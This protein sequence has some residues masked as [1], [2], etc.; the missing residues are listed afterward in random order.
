MIRLRVL[1][2]AAMLF[3]ASFAFGLSFTSNGTGGGNWSSAATW[4]GAGVPGTGDNVTITGSDTVTV[5]DARTCNSVQ[6]DTTGGVKKL[7]VSGT[8]ALVL[9]STGNALLINAPASGSNTVQLNG[10]AL[11]LT[12]GDILIAG[13]TSTVGRLDFNT[14]GGTFTAQQML[15]TGTPSNAQVTFSTGAGSVFLSGNLGNGGSIT[16]GG[17]TFTF[18][19]TGGQTI[20]GYTFNNLTIAK[21]SGTATLNG[22]VFVNG[23]LTISSGLLD[24]GGN[25]IT[26]NAG[27]MSNVNI[28]STGVLKLGAAALATSFPLNIN[29]SNVFF[30]PGSVVVYHAGLTQSINTSFSYRRLWL[31]TTGGNVTHSFTGTLNV[32]E[33]LTVNDNG[34][35]TTTLSVGT[36]SLDVNTDINGDGD[37]SVSS[38]FI[39]L[40]GSWSNSVGLTAGVTSTIVYDGSSAQNVRAATY[41]NLS[42]TKTGGTATLAGA[43]ITNGALGISGTGTLATNGNP[44]TVSGAFGNSATFDAGTSNVTFLGALTNTGTVLSPNATFILGGSSPQVWSS[45]PGAITVSGLQI[46][47][48]TGVT[49]GNNTSVTGSLTLNGGNVTINGSFFVDVPATVT[50][51]SG[52]FIGPLTMGFNPSP[53]RRMHLGTSAAYLPIDLDA[54]SAGTVTARAV[55]GQQPNKTGPRILNRYWTIDSGSV[56]PIDSLTFNYNLTDVASGLEMQFM[57][58]RYASGWI[59]HGDLV[60]EGVHTAT[61]NSIS[62]YVGD[63]DVGH[64]GSMGG[65]GFLKITQVNGGVSPTANVAFGIDV[66]ARTD[67]D[68]ANGNAFTNSTVDITLAAGSGSLLTSSGTLSAG[69]SFVN[70]TGLTYDTAESNVQLSAGTSS[71]DA[72]DSGTSAPFTVLSPPSTLTV[73]SINDSGP[74]TLRDAIDTANAFGCG[75][76]CTINFSTSGTIVLATPLSPISRS[77]VLIDGYTAPGASPNTNAFGLPDN[78]NITM[79]LDGSSTIATGFDVQGQND[80]LKGFVIKNFTT[81]GVKFTGTNTGSG[82][83]GCFVGTDASG[84]NAAPNGDGVGFTASS[85]GTAGGTSAAARN[86]ISGNGMYGVYAGAVSSNI[87]IYGN[88]IGVKANLSGALPNDDGIQVTFGSSANIGMLA[89]GNLI[90]GNTGNG[91]EINGSASVLANLIGTNGNGTAAIPN[92]TGIFISPGATGTAIG[93]SELN[94]ISGNTNQG[95][96]IQ[97]DNNS[98]S[99]AYIGV[100]SDGTTSIPNGGIGVR[101]SGSGTNNSIGVAAAN[102]IAHNAGEGVS[103]ATSALLVGNAIRTNKIFSNGALAIDL[104]QD[105]ITPND[106]ADADGGA[107]GLQNFPT[108]SNAQ[109]SGGN[110]PLSVSVDS[111]GTP[112]GTAALIIDVYKADASSPEQALEYLGNSGCLAGTVFSNYVFTVPQGTVVNGSKIVATATSYVAGCTAVTDGTSELSAAATVNGAIHWIN[113]SGGNWSTAGNWSPAQ[114]PTAS[115]EV[116]IDAGGSYTVIVSTAEAAG[117]LHVGTGISGTQTLAVTVTGSLSLGSA[118]DVTTTGAMSV[119]STLSGTGSLAVNGVFN[120]DGGTIAGSTG[121]TINSG[122]LLTVNNA[123]AH[124]LNQRTLTIASGA[125]A[126]WNAGSIS[127]ANSAHVDNFGLFEIK[128][129][130]TISDAGFDAGFDNLGTLRKSTTAGTTTFSNVDLDHSAGTIDIQTGTIDVGAGSATAP[131]TIFTGAVLLINSDTFTLG[132]GAT[133][134]GLGKIHITSGTLDVTGTTVPVEHLYLQGGTLGG[135]GTITGVFGNTWQWDGGTMSGSGSTI[136]PGGATLLAGSAGSKSLNQRTLQIQGSGTLTFGGSGALQLLNGGNVN[137]AGIFDIIGDAPINDA[138]FGGSIV[139]SGTFKKSGT[140]GGTTS[141]SNVTIANSGTINIQTGTLDPA[142]IN[143]TG[144]ITNAGTLLVNSNTVTLG[145]GS[146]SGAGLVQVT[147]GTLTVNTAVTFPN[148][149]FDG[150]TINGTAVFNATALTWNGG[151]M[152]GTGT[153]NIPASAS[154]TIT[155]AATKTLNQRSFNVAPTGIATFAG[156]GSIDMLNGGNITNNGLFEITGSGGFNDASFAGSIANTGTFRKSTSTNTTSLSN[157]NFNHSGGTLDIQTGT[158]DLAGGTSSAPITLS[159]GTT[160]LVNSNTYTFA[161]G[162]TVSGAGL[163]TVSGGTLSVTGNVAI[164][165]FNLSGGT[166]DGNGTTT[167]TNVADWSGGTMQGGGTTTVDPSATLT[168][169]TGSAKN[170][171]NRTLATVIGG[172]ITASGSGTINLLNGGNVSNAGLFHFTGDAAINDASFAGAFANTGTLRKS[173]STNTTSF[174]NVSLNHT[175]GTLDLQTGTLDL[176]GGTSSA[177]IA[178]ASGATLLFNSN[179]YTL[180][181]G[182]TFTGTGM[183]SLQGG[184]LSVTGNI[185]MPTF[186]MTAG[187]LDGAGTL[188]LTT[189]ADWSGGTMQGGGATT[190]TSGATLTISSP[191]A[192]A[193]NNRTLSTVAGGTIDITG[194][195]T[196]N[197]LNGGNINNAGTFVTD[198][199]STLADAGF[200]G[201]FTNTGTLRKQT[202]TGPTTLTNVA[203]TNNGGIVDLQTG[204]LSTTSFIQSAAGTLKV[205]LG[206]TAPTAFSKLTTTSTPTLAGTLEVTLAGVYQPVGGDVFQILTSPGGAHTGDFTHPYTY[207]ALSGGRTFSDAYNGSG[208]LLTVNGFAD[209]S[210]AKSAASNNFNVSAPISYTITVTNNSP[211]LANSVSVG[212]TLPAGHTGISASGTGWNCNVVG[213]TVTCNA[214]SSLAAGAAP[215]ITINATTPSTPQTFTNTATV[216]SANDGNGTN[217]SSGWPITINPNTVDIDVSS[218]SPASPVAQSTAFT[219]DFTIKNNGPQTATSVVFTAPIP[220]TL[221]FN[222]ATPDQGP[223][224]TFV[225][226]N[227]TCN[228]GTIASGGS[229]HVVL[230]LSTGTTPGT[231]YVT[232]SATQLEADSNLSNNSIPT[233]VQVIGASLTVTNTNDSGAGSL[234]QALL[235]A[236]NTSA[237]PAPCA[238]QFNIGSGPFVIQPQSDLPAVA[239]SA[240]V[241]AT[242]QPGYGGTP[243]IRLDGTLT[244]TTYLL[245]LSNGGSTVKGLSL[246]NATKGIWINSNNNVV[247]DNYIGLTPGSASAGNANGVVIDGSN[248]RIGGTTGGANTIAFN[249]NNGID[250]VTGV[251]NEFTGNSIYNNTL[252]G[253]D[254]ANDGVTP[255]DANDADTGANNLQN[256]PTLTAAFKDASN[257]LHIAYNHD[258]SGAANIAGVLVEIYKAD[259]VAGGQGK[260]FLARNCFALDAFGGGTSFNAPS[261]SVGDPIVLTATGYSDAGCTTVSDGTSEFSNLVTVA[262]CVPPAATINAPPN[263]CASSPSNAAS[264][265]AP[266]ATQFTWTVTGGTLLSGQG[267]ANITFSAPASGSV[268]LSV[269]VRDGNGCPNTPSTS[270]PVVAPPSATITAPPSACA[271]STGNTASAP[272]GASSYLWTITNGTITAGQNT[273]AITFTAGASGSVSLGVTA[274][275]GSCTN[276]G[277]ASVPIGVPP[278]VTIS[279]PA[280]ACPSSTGNNASVAAGASSYL[281]SITNGAITGGQSTNAIT[282]SA[283]ASGTVVLGV[284]V[285]N[286]SCTSNG[287]VS[288]PVTPIVV[289]IT[290]TTIACPSQSFVLDAGAGFA[291]YAWSTGANTRF[292]T[293][294]QSASSVTYNVTVTNGSCSGSD[295]HTVTLGGSPDANITTALNVDAN[296]TDNPAG[297]PAQAGASYSWTIT[298]GTITSG[299]GTNSIL[300]TAGASGVININVTVNAG[301]CSA[302]S[303]AGVVIN[304]VSPTCPSTPPSLLAPANNAIVTSPTAFS[305]SAVSGATSYELWINNALAASIPSTSTSTSITNA[306]PNGA[307]SWFVIARLDGNCIALVSGTRTFSTQTANCGTDVPSLI[308]PPNGAHL[309]NGNVTFQWNGIAGAASYDVS[310]APLNGT[311]VLI[312]STNAGTTSLTHDVPAGDLTWSVTANVDGCPPRAS[313]SATF[314]YTPPVACEDTARPLLI[315]PLDQTVATSPVSFDWNDVA[316]TTRYEVYAIRGNGAPVLIGTS[317]TSSL[318]NASLAT[319]AIRWFVRAFFGQQCSPRDSEERALEIVNVPEPC[320]PLATP[321]L[322]APGEISSGV[323]FLLQWG[324]IP[325][326]TTY[327]VQIDN[328]DSGT[329]SGTVFPLTRTNTG[330]T[331]LAIAARIRAVDMRCSPPKTSEYSATTVIFVL[332]QQQSAVGNVP[333][334]NPIPVH[335]TIALGAE[336]AGQSFIATPTEDWLSVSPASGTV[337]ASGTNLDVTANPNG[338]DVGTHS[339][340]IVVSLNPSSSRLSTNGSTV[341]TTVSV[342]LVTPVTPAP[343]STPT[344][345][346]M[347]IPAVANADGINS[348]FQ[349]DVRV[350]NT[351]AKLIKYQLTFI[352]S[353]DAGSSAGRQTTFSID[354]GQSVALDDVLKSWFGTGTSNAIGVL[355]IK[356]LTTTSSSTSIANFGPL[357]NLV[358]FAASRTFNVTPNGTFGQYIP[359]VPFA[360]FADK[361]TVLSLQQ[362]AQSIK[363]RS[364]LG[365]VEGSGNPADLLIRVFGGNGQQ[366]TS[367]TQHLNGGQHTQLNSFLLERGITLEDGR[368]E[369]QVTSSTGKV[370]AYASVLD[371]ETSDAVLVTP[372]ALTAQGNTKWV[373]PGVAD[374]RSGFADWQSDVRIFNAGTTSIDVTASF[375]S[376]GGG[377]AKVQTITLGAGEVKQLDKILPSLFGVSNDAGALHLSTANASRIIATA[378]TYNQTSKGTYGQFISAVTPQESVAVGTRPLQL[379]QVEESSRMRSNIGFA[380]VTG[381]PVKLEVTV[382]PPDAKFAGVIEVDL[383]PNEYRQIGSLL[384]SLGLGDTYNA[385]ISVRAVSGAGRAT[386]YA[387]VIDLATN[388][389]M[390]V[391]PQ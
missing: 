200:G 95:V 29:S 149:Q 317:N 263:V 227:V 113:G 48:A 367:F 147:S 328:A 354:P 183:V 386:T 258:S 75:T 246:T 116:Y 226:S 371:N 38:G 157:I 192:K 7:D 334:S 140:L 243:I 71:G 336:L 250:V 300:F 359:A 169:S 172:T 279:A 318:A 109:I 135:A 117:I 312:G 118:S 158:F 255:N 355:Q 266:T 120:W 62:T 320:S 179:T 52:W 51:T 96:E 55:E 382:I 215:N 166:L 228:L 122:G 257:D 344:P 129:D 240:I 374:I 98:V 222:S 199:D 234:R 275:T 143:N 285:T 302:S 376:Q 390:Y 176:A 360:N 339:G 380:E 353:G 314:N 282:F 345:D 127:M 86:V 39:N 123:V 291:T 384:A 46:S 352:P 324:A 247:R 361:S 160:F 308:A 64:A 316:G 163:V 305:W 343:S 288:V 34:V 152:G 106:A 294:M 57:L 364:N 290:G 296:S 111:S 193:L 342:N 66:Q 326:A 377:G 245:T 50:R 124:A 83:E 25:Q 76:P 203:L 185:S 194:V 165:Q 211:D 264:V 16:S 37:V 231:H 313:Q 292:I 209:L 299:D 92:D 348:H 114:I 184:T 99:N 24:D 69:T 372:V 27:G 249:G 141:L 49:I 31:T 329:T 195:G 161:A 213:S 375:Y 301:G 335:Y 278:A 385:R 293:V 210:I 357:S 94:V 107:N 254:L 338:L 102:K 100:G 223:P 54:G 178:I 340:A 23:N 125:T 40:G 295:T 60:A 15:F 268:G 73:S 220:S 121:L 2:C 351:S 63:W 261:I 45:N 133:A 59:R 126:N 262:N 235:D 68:S 346:T 138:G 103:V 101:I 170:L 274:G 41:G 84:N 146:I 309:T 70:V 277:A 269:L 196:I 349:S 4:G 379:L 81:T 315:S 322:S 65:A 115:D 232:G 287:S 85:N 35:N 205:R 224:C 242:T 174:S 77:D 33:D 139:N 8:G 17:S 137:N 236:Q 281:W 1:A 74:G 182:T 383:G 202:T 145:A 201:G 119:V 151:T 21:A 331:P 13:G 132:N 189:A 307:S 131:I 188:F 80:V 155:T 72:I 260:T 11:T 47:N 319:G 373:L 381:K 198:V 248:N 212:D 180:A 130:N 272:A 289:N 93:P 128:T 159:S 270:V 9:Q 241:D 175:G 304:A 105:G 97:G 56:V 43:T 363:A 362:I 230:G 142:D 177:P 156:T 310:L 225:S 265:N 350:A 286:G 306:V 256:F 323:E 58:A 44:L 186:G 337:G 20:N 187:T 30:S 150:G 6:L 253:I 82:I 237:C 87:S 214:A 110:V 221:T 61:I 90:S 18:N 341:S 153:T 164:P 19:G 267:T 148:L 67:D 104:G 208:L 5:T 22:A 10:G 280:S 136:V 191:S 389:P 321:V 219:F 366:L 325:G 244:P 42:I 171:N 190:V 168:I 206:G 154:A 388:D 368:V 391:L 89:G 297:V 218:T 144:T 108:L 204:T 14:G 53:A 32:A 330:N 162:T 79:Q 91:I 238:I 333:V 36:G 216:S 332:P 239:A 284:A 356:P 276:N 369:I 12:T 358:S 217:N 26:L 112:S 298:N 181:N 365:L 251:G 252:L 207:P 271:N 167:L 3:A 78:A 283:G 273:N 259:S 378:R 347:I 173:T 327:Q 229:P 387:S 197:F 28:G 370:T 303:A 311:P 88:Y 233:M 134:T